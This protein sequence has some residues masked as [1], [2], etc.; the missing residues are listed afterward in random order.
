M[1]AVTV[2]SFDGIHVGHRAV[3][4]ELRA[5]AETT[6]PSVVVTFEPHPLSVLRPADAPPR[7]SDPAERALLLTDAGID[8]LYVLPFTAELADLDAAAFARRVL[9]EKLR[10]RMLVAG[11]NHRL[12]RDRVGG[13]AELRRLGAAHGFDVRI[14]PPVLVDGSPASSTRV[15]HAI[16]AGDLALAERLL[17]RPYGVFAPVV[18]GAGRGRQLGV[19]TANLAVPHSKHMPPAG[20]YAGRASVDGD[21][22]PAAVHWGGVPTFGDARLGLE[23]HLL[24]FSGDLYGR[25]VELAFLERLRDVEAF[26]DAE[27]LARAMRED[28]RRTAQVVGAL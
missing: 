27:T 25:W 1:S 6:L 20:I 22:F 4:R 15:R 3:L 14:V 16:G 13:P 23:A 28:V 9:V 18:P 5:A 21:R 24:G 10:C 12:G 8:R 11:E 19:P 7:L 17:G 26:A 2:G